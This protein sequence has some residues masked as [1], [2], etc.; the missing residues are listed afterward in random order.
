[1]ASKSLS[2]SST[3]VN[4]LSDSKMA[5]PEHPN[6][7]LERTPVRFPSQAMTDF[8]NGSTQATGIFRNIPYYIIVYLISI[9]IYSM[10]IWISLQ[11][12]FDGVGLSGLLS[13]NCPTTVTD[14]V[15]RRQPQLRLT[16]VW[17]RVNYVSSRVTCVW[18]PHQS[19]GRGA[20]RQPPTSPPSLPL[21]PPT[22]LLR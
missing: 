18:L 10:S 2:S 8:L 5:T 14:E 1:M 16:Y 11:S 4:H 6:L 17:S 15:L 13:F 21:S 20:C 3:P 7:T 12:L 19:H 9:S 22:P